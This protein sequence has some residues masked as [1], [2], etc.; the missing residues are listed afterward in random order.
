MITGLL[1]LAALFTAFPYFF[2]YI[3]KRDGHTINDVVLNTITTANVSIPLFI[4]IWCMGVYMGIKA[5]EQPRQLL[6]FLWAFLFLS[7]FRITCIWL[8]A[9]NPPP[10][11]IPLSDPIANS[12]YGKS[13]I[14]KDLFYSGH[15]ATI[16]LIFLCLET[17]PQKIA[18]LIATV[19]VGS[20]VL[21]QHI[22][23]T[24]DVI[25]APV[26]AYLC[27]YICNKITAGVNLELQS[28]ES[29]GAMLRA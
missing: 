5:I 4:T 1:L 11:L 16:F 21:V 14:T 20:L 6:L 17:K 2:Q 13:F 27:F 12:F 28:V 8:V 22:H 9:L 29:K 25:A 26:F 3:Q 24:V 10:G 19:I 15:T 23:Y 18:A 7:A